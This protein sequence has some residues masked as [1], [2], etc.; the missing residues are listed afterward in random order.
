M[1]LRYLWAGSLCRRSDTRPFRHARMSLRYL[2]ARSPC[3]RP[4]RSPLRHAGMPLK[5]LWAWSPCRSHTEDLLGIVCGTALA[6]RAATEVPVGRV[7][8]PKTSQKSPFATPGCLWSTCRP[9]LRAD[10][11]AVHP[12]RTSTS[13]KKP[14]SMDVHPLRT[15]TSIKK[16][17]SM[18]T[19][20]L[21]TSMSMKTATFMDAHTIHTST[22]R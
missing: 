2:W 21:R 22:D 16:P 18:D 6:R 3:R 4:V 9:T 11:S 7:A 14:D 8:V 10:G 15:S 20:P 1:P 13:I 17:D 12:L 19:H 5:Y